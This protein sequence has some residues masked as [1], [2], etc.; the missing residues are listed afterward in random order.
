MVFVTLL[1]H[2]HDFEF[3]AIWISEE[4]SIIARDIVVLSWRVENLPSVRL[5]LF[6]QRINLRS[7]LTTESDFTEADSV[8]IEG[9][10]GKARV[11]L[12]D[13]EAALIFRS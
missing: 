9:V 10:G 6:C 3:D 7:A 4:H 1:R 13:P 12:F 5:Y 8:F 11:G 2:M